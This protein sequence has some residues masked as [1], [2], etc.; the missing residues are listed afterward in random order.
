M[1][2]IGILVGSLRKEAFS[3]KIAQYAATQFPGDFEIVWLDISQLTIFNQDLEEEGMTPPSWLQFREQVKQMDAFLFV[4]PE[5]NRSF[6]AA[7]KN[8]LD[9]GSRPFGQN[10]WSGKPGAIISVSPGRLGG[11][12]SNHHLRQSFSFLNC[13]IMPQ[14]E[15]YIGDVES[16]LDENGAVVNERTQSSLHHFATAFAE[17]IALFSK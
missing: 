11:F 4:T 3:R 17:W 1:K 8:A 10:L 9:I 15:M 16:L 14:P 12:G 5:Y 13:Y 2:K 7:I 6:P